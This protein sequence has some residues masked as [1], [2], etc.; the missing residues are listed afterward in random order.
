[1]NKKVKGG[2]IALLIYIAITVVGMVFGTLVVN[3]V[4]D[5]PGIEIPV[6]IAQITAGNFLFLLTLVFK[7]IPTFSILT[8]G[9]IF[10]FLSGGLIWFGAGYLFGWLTIKKTKKEKFNFIGGALMRVSL[11]IILILT[12]L[13][14]TLDASRLGMSFTAFILIMLLWV[15]SGPLILGFIFWLISKFISEE[16][17]LIDK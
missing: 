17:T 11:A 5:S 2:L 15:W 12:L 14:F 6:L 9:H 13:F 4:G 10:A 1:M 7:G 16:S 8:A 3:V